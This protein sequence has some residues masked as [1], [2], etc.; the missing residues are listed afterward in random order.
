MISIPILVQHRV[1]ILPIFGERILKCNSHFQWRIIWST[2]VSVVSRSVIGH[3]PSRWDT[4]YRSLGNAGDFEEDIN[5]VVY[6]AKHKLHLRSVSRYARQ[7]D[8]TLQAAPCVRRNLPARKVSSALD[9]RGKEHSRP[10]NSSCSCLHSVDCP[11]MT[12]IWNKFTCTASTG[13]DVIVCVPWSSP[14][15][16]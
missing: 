7:L 15:P 12:V 2:A 5:D 6:F 13:S 11:S 4:G 8:T 3:Q 10:G 16:I 1:T 14:G 9:P